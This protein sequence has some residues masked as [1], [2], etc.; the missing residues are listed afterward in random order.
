MKKS[1][2]FLLL[3]LVV[4]MIVVAIQYLTV[5][6]RTIINCEHPNREYTF[7]VTDDSIF[8]FTEDDK[9][10]GG[11]KL[12]GQLDSLIIADNE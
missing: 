2:E 1:T 11:V 7:D 5:D 12:E 10:V 6:K 4:T 9:F 3:V 8:V